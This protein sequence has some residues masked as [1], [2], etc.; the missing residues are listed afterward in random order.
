MHLLKY[1]NNNNNNSFGKMIGWK[2]VSVFNEQRTTIRYPQAD[3]FRLQSSRFRR[4]N[5]KCLEIVHFTMFSDDAASVTS[6]GLQE[7]SKWNGVF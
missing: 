7:L 5:N 1:N 4:S 2:G 3:F 6:L